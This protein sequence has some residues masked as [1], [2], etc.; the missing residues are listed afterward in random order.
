M[1]TA[2]AGFCFVVGAVA[3]LI[4][5]SLIVDRMKSAMRISRETAVQSYVVDG[6]FRAGKALHSFLYS[7]V[8]RTAR[9]KDT[10]SSG[11]SSGGSRGGSTHTS[12]HSAGGSYSSG[13][14][15]F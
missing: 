3:G 13:G 2:T 12:G 4:A 7:T 6:S 5:A 14:R 1:H 9:P 11:S 10:G 15:R 8:S